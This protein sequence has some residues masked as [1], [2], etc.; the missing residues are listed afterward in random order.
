MD[1]GLKEH[2]IRKVPKLFSQ[3]ISSLPI[4]GKFLIRGD[5]NA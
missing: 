3:Q 2:E 4:E 1:Y 5:Q